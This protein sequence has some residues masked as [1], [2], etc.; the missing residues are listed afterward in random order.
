MRRARCLC[1]HVFVFA[2]LGGRAPDAHRGP[3]ARTAATRRPQEICQ[4]AETSG[5]AELQSFELCCCV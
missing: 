2:L 4:R 1:L 3:L 5:A